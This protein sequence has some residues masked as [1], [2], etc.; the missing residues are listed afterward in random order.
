MHATGGE[1]KCWKGY[2]GA[3][4]ASDGSFGLFLGNR[5]GSHRQTAAPKKGQKASKKADTHKA[6]GKQAAP[7][8]APSKDS[9]EGEPETETEAEAETEA[10]DVAVAPPS[11]PLSLFRAALE[12]SAFTESPA[13]I[14]KVVDGAAVWVPGAP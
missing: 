10:D 13:L 2:T 11:G 1:Y 8:R 12:G 7:R 9:P 4:I 5:D 3:S 6:R 14:V